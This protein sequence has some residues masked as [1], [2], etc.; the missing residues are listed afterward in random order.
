MITLT[1]YNFRFPTNKIQH[2]NYV[3]PGQ[4]RY[5]T[6]QFRASSENRQVLLFWKNEPE[7]SRVEGFK[8]EKIPFED[9]LYVGNLMNMPVVI[10]LGKTDDIYDLYYIRNNPDEIKKCPKKKHYTS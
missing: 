1:N 10:V 7:I 3:T 2:V 6:V 9:A 8:N 5:H 4:R